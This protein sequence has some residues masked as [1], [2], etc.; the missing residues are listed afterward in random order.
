MMRANSNGRDMLFAITEKLSACQGVSLL[1]LASIAGVNPVPRLAISGSKKLFLNRLGSGK[2]L[3]AVSRE[4]VKPQ[5]I[6]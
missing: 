5:L 3:R 2:E 1:S 6:Q 4:Q